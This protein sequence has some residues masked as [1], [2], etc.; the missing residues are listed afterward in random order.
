[1]ICRIRML[2]CSR[3][4]NPHVGHGPLFW[5]RPP[6]LKPAGWWYAR[7]SFSCSSP[8][9]HREELWCYSYLPLSAFFVCIGDH[10]RT[11]AHLQEPLLHTLAGKHAQWLFGGDGRAEGH[12]ESATPNPLLPVSV[13]SVTV[14]FLHKRSNYS[15]LF[16]HPH[17]YWAWG[18]LACSSGPCR[19][20]Q[21]APEWQRRSVV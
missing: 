16:N 9:H 14:W 13:I 8:L 11:V 3:K 5:L 20:Q 4:P 19:R 6:F 21:R 7:A 18:L 2:S 17:I 10:T 12:R 15:E 1:M